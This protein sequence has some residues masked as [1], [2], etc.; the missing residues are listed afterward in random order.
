MVLTKDNGIYEIF[1]EAP[2][3]NAARL[4]LQL[5]EDCHF[6]FYHTVPFDA[7]DVMYM[8]CLTEW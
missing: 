2:Q 4:C 5:L 3:W 7:V 6:Y 1:L 8:C